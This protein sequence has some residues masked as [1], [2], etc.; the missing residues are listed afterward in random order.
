MDPTQ[1]Q[2][3]NI[4]Q[5]ISDIYLTSNSNA[6]TNLQNVYQQQDHEN[7]MDFYANIPSS[8]PT[9]INLQSDG[10]DY[11]QGNY[12]IDISQLFKK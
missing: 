3:L 7:M 12:T 8:E 11:V 5:N 4:L 1:Y 6:Q 10:E 2:I 9:F